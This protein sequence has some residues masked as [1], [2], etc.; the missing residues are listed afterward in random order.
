[1]LEGTRRGVALLL[2]YAT[3]AAT[4]PVRADEVWRE[5]RTHAASERFAV[6]PIG[7]AS[8]AAHAADPLQQRLDD[9]GRETSEHVAFNAAIARAGGQ[10]HIFPAL[11]VRAPRQHLYQASDFTLRW[12]LAM[13]ARRAAEIGWPPW[14]RL[15]VPS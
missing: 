13:L 10:L 11:Q 7:L 14:R 6:D 3:V 15:F 8:D 5:S 2:V 1:M 12:R 9:Q 4:M